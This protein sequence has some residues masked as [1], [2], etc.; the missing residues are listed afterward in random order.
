MG[1]EVIGYIVR[2]RRREIGKIEGKRL[3]KSFEK[4]VGLTVVKFMSFT[5]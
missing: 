2:E 3:K 4:V 1:G 5:G